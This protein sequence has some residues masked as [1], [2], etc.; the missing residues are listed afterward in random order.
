MP[1]PFYERLK[2]YYQKVGQVLRGEADVASIFPNTTDIGWSRERIYAEFLRLHLPSSCN[3]MFG[4]FIFNLTGDESKQID[5][6]VTVDVCPQYNFENRDGR[7]KSFSCIEGTL[8][9]VSLK[10]NLDSRELINAL[11]NIAS[12][13]SK[14]PLGDKAMPQVNI[15]NYDEWPYKIIYAP[16]GVSSETLSNTLS[17]YYRNNP[18]IPFHRK[19]NLIHVAG[20]YNIVRL[21]D[22]DRQATDGQMVPRNTFV[23]QKD[24]T[25]R[26]ALVYAVERIQSMC[27]SARYIL[28]DYGDIMDNVISEI[29]EG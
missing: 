9:V 21:D 2:D 12:L 1:R 11:D 18:D 7:G 14:L 15:P 27:V 23:L 10:S 8:A 5:V 26:F 24:T 6:I 16:N 25:D 22:D 3:V 19:P 20:R 28:F 29:E 13:P 17:E 4:G